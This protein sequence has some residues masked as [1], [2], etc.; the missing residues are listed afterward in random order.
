MSVFLGENNW[1]PIAP[2]VVLFWFSHL[3]ELNL[4]QNFWTLEQIA[5]GQRS[6]LRSFLVRFPSKDTTCRPFKRSV[7]IACFTLGGRRQCEQTSK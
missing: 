4:T 2:D 5:W 3:C 6:C 1:M 7:K